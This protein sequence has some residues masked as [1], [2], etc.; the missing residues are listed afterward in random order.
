MQERSLSPLDKYPSNWYE[1]EQRQ[2]PSSFSP[3]SSRQY[4]PQGIASK[5]EVIVV[6]STKP[7]PQGRGDFKNCWQGQRLND[8]MTQDAHQGHESNTVFQ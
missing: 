6:N 7:N 2:Q 4:S 3:P 5:F 8:T 1:A